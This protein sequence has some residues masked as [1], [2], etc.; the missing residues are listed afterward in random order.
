M[1]NNNSNNTRLILLHP[2]VQKQ[3]SSSKKLWFLGFISLFPLAFLV[4][5]IYM[6]ETATV[7]VS[8]GTVSSSTSSTTISSSTA[9]YGNAPLP[10]TVINTLLHYAS[11]S[12]DMF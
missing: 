12:K 5:F 8:G 7:K 4:T 11:R 10:T 2:Y 3:G 6:R 1:K 9:A